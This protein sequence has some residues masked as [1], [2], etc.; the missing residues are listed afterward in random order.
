MDELSTPK[1]YSQRVTNL[2]LL[3]KAER[4]KKKHPY[5]LKHNLGERWWYP[6]HVLTEKSVDPAIRAIP[7]SAIDVSA[8]PFDLDREVVENWAQAF[9]QNDT[10]IL[11]PYSLFADMTSLGHGEF[12]RACADIIDAHCA[13]Y[14]TVAVIDEHA[15]GEWFFHTLYDLPARQAFRKKIS[16]EFNDTRTRGT[17][18]TEAAIEKEFAARLRK[19]GHTVQR[20]VL[21]GAG[22]ADIV[23]ESAV[24]EIKKTL[25]RDELFKALGQVLLYREALGNHLRPVIVGHCAPNVYL[26]TEFA[27]IRTLGVEVILLGGSDE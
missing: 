18:K 27:Y 2:R 21:C 22:K 3:E 23:T 11:W 10:T 16:E 6:L 25:R 13:A 7:L 26:G 1:V 24:Y 17:Q 15:N 19:Q 14:D 8:C 20:Q 12:G 9:R 5:A 4:L